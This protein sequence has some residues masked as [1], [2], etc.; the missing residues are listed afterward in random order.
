VDEMH[1]LIQCCRI[2]SRRL[3]NVNLQK[4]KKKKKKKKQKKKKKK[5]PSSSLSSQHGFKFLQSILG[6]RYKKPPET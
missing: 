3:T 6:I 1:R 5:K 4:K 2:K